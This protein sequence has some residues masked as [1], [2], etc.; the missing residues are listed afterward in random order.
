M[1]PFCPDVRP[2]RGHPAHRHGARWAWTWQPSPRI[3]L[4]PARASTDAGGRPCPPCPD[5]GAWGGGGHLMWPRMVP[6]FQ[7]SPPGRQQVLAG[8]RVA[9]SP[10]APRARLQTQLGHQHPDPRQPPPPPGA[11]GAE[12][13]LSPSRPW[14]ELALSGHCPARAMVRGALGSLPSGARSVALRT[15][16]GSVPAQGPAL[17]Q[18]RT[19]ALPCG[20]ASRVPLTGWPSAGHEPT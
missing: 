5:P 18:D 6:R 4:C 2:H 16:G 20:R 13:G 11:R 1:S 7:L 19:G 12:P 10:A 14:A 3:W 15:S 9:A 8:A 17:G